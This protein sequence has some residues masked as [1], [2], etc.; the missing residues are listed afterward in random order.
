MR[1]EVHDMCICVCERERQRDEFSKIL[2]LAHVPYS[3]DFETRIEVLDGA[4]R[5]PDLQSSC[6]DWIY[7]RRAFTKMFSLIIQVRGS[8]KIRISME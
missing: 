1:D 8:K 3:D 2:V 6:G 5:V 4:V 7:G